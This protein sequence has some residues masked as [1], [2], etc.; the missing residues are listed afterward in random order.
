M[1]E[2]PTFARQVY[3]TLTVIRTVFLQPPSGNF[4]AFKRL[5]VQ[6]KFEATERNP[7]GK[8]ANGNY[9]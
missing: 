3:L 2:L 4:E 8:D 7:S 9:D 5:V 1:L 6:W